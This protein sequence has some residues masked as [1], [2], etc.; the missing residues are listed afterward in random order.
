MQRRAFTLL[1][2]LVVIAII[3]TLIGLLLPAVQKVR[4]AAMRAKSQNNLKQICLALHNYGSTHDR[5]PAA[6]GQPHTIYH[7]NSIYIE[8][9]PYLEQTRESFITG[10]INTLV[11]PADPTVPATVRTAP[12]PVSSYGAN[13]Q[14]FNGV[15]THAS[16]MDGTSTTIAFAEHY[17]YDCSGVVFH[18]EKSLSFNPVLHRATFADGGPILGGNTFDDV[19]PITSGGITVPSRP[20]ATFQVSPRFGGNNGTLVE[21]GGPIPLPGYCDSGLPQT[22][23]RGLLVAMAD[24]AVRTVSPGVRP[25]VFWGAVTPAGGEVAAID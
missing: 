14:A 13:A 4:E 22:P 23:H 25:E 2:L 9:A 20:G 7:G 16:F 19:Y 18:A 15:P 21:Y 1:E 5:F 10:F 17:A 6:N 8:I 24:G 3:G 12:I 11:S